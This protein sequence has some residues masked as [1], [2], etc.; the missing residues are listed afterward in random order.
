MIQT[1]DAAGTGSGDCGFKVED[2]IV[3]AL[4]YDRA[5]RLGLARLAEPNTG[6]CQFFITAAPY[7]SL[8]GGYTIFRQVVE[9]QE[10]VDKG[11]AGATRFQRQAADARK[12]YRDCDPGPVRLLLVER[13]CADSMTAAIVDGVGKR[14]AAGRSK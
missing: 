7:P 5:G 11:S 10:V 8:N 13:Y 1:G 4:K 9:G 2:E 3:P 12:A 6:A 14:S